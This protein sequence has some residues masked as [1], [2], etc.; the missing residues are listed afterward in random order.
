M[1]NLIN[2]FDGSLSLIWADSTNNSAFPSPHDIISHITSGFSSNQL[3]AVRQ[4]DSVDDIPSACPPNFN[5]FSQ[6]FA[7][8][9]FD[10]F[11][12]SASDDVRPINYTIHADGGLFH[13]DVVRHKSDY[14]E[15]LLPLQWAIDSVGSLIQCSGY[16]ESYFVPPSPLGYHRH[17]NR[18]QGRHSSRMAVHAGVEPRTRLRHSLKY[19]RFDTLLLCLRLISAFEGYIRGLRSLLVIAL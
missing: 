11:P 13:I 17:H 19:V 9:S 4:V 7:A 3:R 8:I 6:C 5:L 18:V 16:N 15:R 12:T 14:E 1:F 10:S 2:Q